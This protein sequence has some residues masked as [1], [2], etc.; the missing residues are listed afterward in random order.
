MEIGKSFSKGELSWSIK[1]ESDEPAGNG[2]INGEIKINI[3]NP[4]KVEFPVEA[5]VQHAGRSISFE[6][7]KPMI[8]FQSI[9][10][11]QESLKFDLGERG[12]AEGQKSENEQ[13]GD[14]EQSQ[15]WFTD[16]GERGDDYACR[17][18]SKETISLCLKILSENIDDEKV[19]EQ[20]DKPPAYTALRRRSRYCTNFADHVEILNFLYK[21][22]NPARL[23]SDVEEEVSRFIKNRVISGDGGSRAY[24]SNSVSE[25][26]R[27]IDICES[28]PS[29]AISDKDKLIG[30]QQLTVAGDLVDDGEFGEAKKRASKAIGRLEQSSSGEPLPAKLQR[31]AISGLCDESQCEFEGAAAHYSNAAEKAE[32]TENIQAYETWSKV[33]KIKQHLNGGS[34]EKARDLAGEINYSHRNI[35]LID[36][37][38]LTKLLEVYSEYSRGERSDPAAIFADVEIKNKDELPS[39]DAIVQF[40]PD[41]SAAFTM[42]VTSQRR[43]QLG[44]DSGIDDDFRTIV[45]DAITPTGIEETA[46]SEKQLE[47]GGTQQ[48]QDVGDMEEESEGDFEREY[49]QAKRAQR[50][51]QFQGDV[52]EAYNQTCAVCE[53]KRMTPDGRPEVEAAHIR[54]VSEGGKDTVANGIALC[55]LHHWAFDN[56]W[57]SIEDDYSIVVRDAPEVSGYE[58]F[59]QYQESRLNLPVSDKKKPDKDALG[60]HRRHHGFENDR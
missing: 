1:Y 21:Y 54:A 20:I 45:R 53:S 39:S 44:I 8:K 31:D 51:S 17:F 56:G 9:S 10:N 42:L 18:V 24:P 23:D 32:D 16:S 13:L 7:E 28:E 34:L 14:N 5:G 35:Y 55:R 48:H 36:L 19:I 15:V 50:D 59:A 38:K 2:V 37:Q 46:N 4:Q 22:T 43:Q 29:L 26:E 49:T 11:T 40:N 47:Q 60:F 57:I 12:G 25:V 6:S 3:L 33:A 41:Y 30:L 52:K 27:R 58:D